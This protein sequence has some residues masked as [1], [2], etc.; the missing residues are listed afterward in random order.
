[1]IAVSTVGDGKLRVA[2]EV[3]IPIPSSPCSQWSPG[4][5]RLLA[6]NI[7]KIINDTVEAAEIVDAAEREGDRFGKQR[8]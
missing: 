5:M 6:D 1:M 8:T 7:L 3:E 2:L 4:R